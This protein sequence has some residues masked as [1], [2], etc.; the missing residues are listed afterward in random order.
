MKIPFYDRLQQEA[1]RDLWVRLMLVCTADFPPDPV[2]TLDSLATDLARLLPKGPL[3]D[4]WLV[5]REGLSAEEER[6]VFRLG[7]PERIPPSNLLPP[8]A[9]AIVFD[10]TPDLSSPLGRRVAV[11]VLHRTEVGL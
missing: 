9:L 2:L 3:P 4:R 8:N 1:A 6:G 5:R 10:E 7:L 11:T